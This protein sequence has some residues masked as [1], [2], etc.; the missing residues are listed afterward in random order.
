MKKAFF[1]ITIMWALAFI[2]AT[3]TVR[4]QEPLL[5]NIPFA[6][7]AG[8]MALPAGEYRVEK[9]AGGSL[10]LLIQRT[11]RSAAAFVPSIAAQGNAPQTQSKL[12]FHR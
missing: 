1:R 7:T 12:V 8:K 4:A 10:M 2:A 3:Q 6:F 9:S 5:V 11:D